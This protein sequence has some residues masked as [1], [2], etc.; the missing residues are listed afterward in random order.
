MLRFNVDTFST[1]VTIR[2]SRPAIGFLPTP[3]AP[4]AWDT[5]LNA[6]V[7]KKRCN[8]KILTASNK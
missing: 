4:R 5:S 6:N 7:A 2:R 3:A 8:S 1:C